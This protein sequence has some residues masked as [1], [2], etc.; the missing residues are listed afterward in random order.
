MIKRVILHIDLAFAYLSKFIKTRL[1]YKAD[2]LLGLFTGVLFQLV[3]L[4]FIDVLFAKQA[5][6]IGGWT[7]WH[8]LFI[9]GFSIFPLNLFFAFF[10]NL[11][12]VG[13]KY[14]I[15]GNLDRILLRPLNSLF[16]VLMEEVDI[17][18]LIGL[19]VGAGIVFYASAQLSLEWTLGRVLIFAIMA[20][21]GMLIYGGVFTT[22][23]SFSF[24]WPDRIG[25]MAPL[26][27]MIAFGKYPVTIY[28]RLLQCILMWVIPF[29]FVAF[30][31]ATYFLGFDE[32]RPFVLLIPV[33]AAVTMAVGISMWNLGIRHYEST[34]S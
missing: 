31:P 2:L 29:A 21:C 10:P 19:I 32:F 17:E 1:E 30:F 3:T 34:G 5:L 25:L 28:N 16:Q 9:Y 33:I 20:F 11:Y 27:N 24:W 13:S 14:I 23:A 22:V 15:E 8:V 12:N 26:F 18:S 4:I 6:T 7:K